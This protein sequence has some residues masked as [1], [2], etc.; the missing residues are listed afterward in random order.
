[1]Q[2]ANRGPYADWFLH[3]SQASIAIRRVLDELHG[4]LR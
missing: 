1:V 2:R 4:R 3:E